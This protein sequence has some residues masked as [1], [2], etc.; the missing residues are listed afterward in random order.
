MRHFT[1]AVM[2][3]AVLLSLCGVSPGAEAEPSGT[4]TLKYDAR[5]AS[6]AQTPAMTANYNRFSVGSS[7]SMGI[8]VA[9]K[10]VK[11]SARVSGGTFYLGFDRDGNGTISKA[12]WGVIPKSGTM[13]ISGKSGDLSYVIRLVKMRVSYNKKTVSCWGQTVIRSSMAGTIG[14]VPVRILDD[15]MDGKFSQMPSQFGDAIMIGSSASAIPL[16]RVHRIG[17]YI[18]RLKVAE[19]G[20]S[21]DYERMDDVE[22]GLV[23]ATFPSNSLKSLVLV[24]KDAAFNI[25]TDGRAGIPAGT[26]KL[27]YGT[28]GRSTA[29]LLFKPGRTTP[30]YE[31]QAKMV[32]T[33]RIGSPVRM[34]FAA[35]FRAGKV[36][37]SARDVVLIG[38]GSEI[39][40]P[41][42]FTKG[43]NAKPPK[44]IMLNGR[45]VVSASD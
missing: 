40:G 36:R 16:R 27:A 39:Y 7:S 45:R 30:D 8:K 24:S 25:K 28:V 32:N 15:N 26:Y 21:I 17:K 4:A 34:D 18:Y 44:V 31:I 43:G 10:T 9:G 42:N 37:L 3:A 13:L 29:G 35:S 5:G 1:I 22:L 12:E 23:N 2:A 41:L 11:T 14:W 38:S 6:R 33:L 19:D 20:S